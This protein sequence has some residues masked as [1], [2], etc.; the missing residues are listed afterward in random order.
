MRPGHT[1]QGAIQNFIRIL[2]ALSL[3]FSHHT[4]SLSPKSNYSSELYGDNFFAFL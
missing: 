3:P 2:E 1:N 4:S